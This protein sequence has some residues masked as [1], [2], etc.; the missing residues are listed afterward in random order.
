MVK[1]SHLNS[2]MKNLLMIKGTSGLIILFCIQ[3][4]LSKE[5]KR[6][7]IELFQTPKLQTN[8]HYQYCIVT[9]K[10]IV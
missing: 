9:F 4:H 8:S 6:K 10:S 5:G 1:I 7:K 3:F 2:A